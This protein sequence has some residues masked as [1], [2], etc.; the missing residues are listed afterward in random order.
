MTINNYNEIIT[1]TI[2]GNKYGLTTTKVPYRDRGIE[3]CCGKLLHQWN[4]SYEHEITLLTEDELKELET[5]NTIDT[6]LI[7]TNSGE[8]LP[9]PKEN[10]KTTETN[11]AQ[12]TI[13]DIIF[14]K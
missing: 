5:K 9:K 2:C 6:K 13:D 8:N 12:T 1:C 7:K 4:E 10:K 14:N 3:Y 11:P